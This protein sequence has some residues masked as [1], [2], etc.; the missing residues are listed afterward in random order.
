MGDGDGNAGGNHSDPLKGNH[1]VFGRG[2][3]LGLGVHGAPVYLDWALNLWH[4]R[5]FIDP[6]APGV[7]RSAA[8]TGYSRPCRVTLRR[9]HGPD[10]PQLLSDDYGAGP[11]RKSPN[12]C[13]RFRLIP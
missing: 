7:L 11:R 10:A 2:S 13:G 3:R 6:G 5:A 9:L 1:F 4:R 8:K 12:A